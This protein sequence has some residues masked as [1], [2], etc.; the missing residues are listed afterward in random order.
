MYIIIKCDQDGDSY[1]IHFD[2]SAADKSFNTLKQNKIHHQNCYLAEIIDTNDFG[3]D[4]RG[5]LYGAKLIDKIE[6]N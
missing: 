5:D 6:A 2:L 3:F 4:Q 1:E